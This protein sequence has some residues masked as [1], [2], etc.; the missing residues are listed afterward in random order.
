MMN[1]EMKQLSRGEYMQGIQ[2]KV[3]NISTILEHA[4]ELMLLPEAMHW[5]GNVCFELAAMSELQDG[6]IALRRYLNLR[7]RVPANSKDGLRSAI[8]AAALNLKSWLQSV[9]VSCSEVHCDDEGML[10]RMPPLGYTFVGKAPR[11]S[12]DGYTAVRMPLDGQCAI[13]L[14]DIEALLYRYPMSGITLQ[15]M[16]DRWKAM[17][18][19]ALERFAAG[20]GVPREELRETLSNGIVCFN[21]AMWGNGA[22][23]ISDLV[24]ATCGGKAAPKPVRSNDGRVAELLACDPWLMHG[25]INASNRY[26]GVLTAKELNQIF[27]CVPIRIEIGTENQPSALANEEI[28]QGMI[29]DTVERMTQLMRETADQTKKETQ[30]ILLT[31]EKKLSDEIVNSEQRTTEHLTRLTQEVQDQTQKQVEE[32]RCQ[33]ED[34]IQAEQEATQDRIHRAVNETFETV[35]GE[36]RRSTQSL[37]EQIAN[38]GTGL[39]LLRRDQ[40][41]LEHLLQ[42]QLMLS[43]QQ[44]TELNDLL[45]AMTGERDTLKRELLLHIARDPEHPLSENACALLG[46][47]S[48]QELVDEGMTERQLNI[49]RIAMAC[50]EGKEIMNSERAV[51]GDSTYYHPYIIFFGFLYEQMAR[52]FYHNLVYVPYC[53]R[54]CCGILADP[55][56]RPNDVKLANYEYGPIDRR[57]IDLTAEEKQ[58]RDAWEPGLVVSRLSCGIRFG[59]KKYGEPV[60]REIL[61]MMQKVRKIRNKIHDLEMSTDDAYE[62]VNLMVRNNRSTMRG[63]P[64]LIRWFVRLGQTTAH[65]EEIP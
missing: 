23:E 58:A 4:Y 51:S 44:L 48:E 38:V 62:M 15:L 21:F 18:V 20:G 30:N 2:L 12:S 24:I 29:H 64:C 14:P 65:F 22:R 8:D 57:T 42:N 19:S 53:N 13:N 39:D 46:I 6:R 63:Y 28:L 36:L 10:I 35:T 7:M 52:Y 26:A 60:W 5:I 43:E 41:R 31:A 3:Q 25:K 34:R 61:G 37:Q 56:G 11:R 33:F 27:S 47:A 9:S 1:L 55:T 16:P 54:Y 32:I 50:I 49:L 59:Q 17:E 40:E 45:N